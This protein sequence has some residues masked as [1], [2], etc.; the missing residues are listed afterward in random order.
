VLGGVQLEE[1]N[2]RNGVPEAMS[3]HAIPSVLCWKLIVPSED[4][5]G[6]S[7]H[8]KKDH[9]REF[10]IMLCPLVVEFEDKENTMLLPCLLLFTTSNG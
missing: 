2:P 1:K 9:R 3:Y 10:K 7:K 5:K 8:Q 6:T 4:S